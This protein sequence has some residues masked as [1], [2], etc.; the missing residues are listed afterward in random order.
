MRRAKNLCNYQPPSM[1]FSLSSTIIP[2]TRVSI[3]V[4]LTPIQPFFSTQLPSIRSKRTRREQTV[5]P[6]RPTLGRI[7]AKNPSMEVKN[8][9]EILT[10]LYTSTF[11]CG[12][13][14]FESAVA[15]ILVFIQIASPLPLASW[16]SWSISPS[17]A[18][19][20]SPDTKVPRT[21]ELALRKAI[22]ANANMKAIQDS[23]EDISYL[24]RIPQRKP[25]GTMEGNVKKALKV[26]LSHV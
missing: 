22:P 20:Y 8:R 1:A 24:L 14:S 3:N 4:S 19:L 7:L 9:H 17:E 6:I 26:S 13:K 16:N 5:A 18:V 12:R 15:V 11:E 2:H 23:L 21:G 10:N 25:Y